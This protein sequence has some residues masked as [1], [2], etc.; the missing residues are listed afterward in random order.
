MTSIGLPSFD[1]IAP[2]ATGEFQELTSNRFDA[3]GEAGANIARNNETRLAFVANDQQFALTRDMQNIKRVIAET[4]LALKGR[5]V[6]LNETTIESNALAKDV[7]S[8]TIQA[9]QEKIRAIDINDPNAARMLNTLTNNITAISA[10]TAQLG[11]NVTTQ[12]SRGNG[13]LQ[14]S[15]SGA[16][17]QNSVT[18]GQQIDANIAVTGI[19][20]DTQLGLA[21]TASL[22]QLGLSGDQ[23]DVSFQQIDQ[24]GARVAT[25]QQ[26]ALIGQGNQFTGVGLGTAGFNSN[27]GINY[28]FGGNLGYGLPYG[29]PTMPMT[30][31][32]DFGMGM[33]SLG[34]NNMGLGGIGGIGSGSIITAY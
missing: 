16:V 2:S 27:Y 32:M 34:M 28:D 3:F 4:N 25:G 6:N 14:T 31:M 26:A 24:V 13:S 9:L 8:A 12:T 20:A 10:S 29:A 19:N 11:A 33:T 30:G 18:T 7:Q 15:Q 21:G 22:T 5:Q 1:T 23:R 17:G